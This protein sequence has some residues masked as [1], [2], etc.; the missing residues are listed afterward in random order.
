MLKPFDPRPDFVELEHEIAVFWQN[1]GIIKKYLHKNDSA[2]DHFSFLDGPITANNPMGVHHA[3]GRTLKDAFQR[4]HTMKG[5]KQR[6]QNGFDC[7]GLWVEVEVEK[8]L[9]VKNKKEIEN[10]VPGDSFASLAKFVELCKERVRKFSAVQT[11]QSE[12]LGYWMNWDHSYFT[13]ADHNNYA[14]WNFLKV[15]HERDWIYLGT[16][17][18]PWCPR[19]GT[20]ISQQEILS[21]EYHELTHNSVYLGL[22]LKEREDERLLIWTTTPWTIPANIFVAVHPELEYSLVQFEGKKYWVMSSRIEAVFG[23]GAESERNV[24]G[25]ELVNLHYSAP[26]DEL[27]IYKEAITKHYF[28]EVLAAPELVGEGEGTGLVHIAPAAGGEDYRLATREYKYDDLVIEV[29]DEAGD[30]VEGFGELSGKN[31][32]QHPELILDALGDFLFKTAKYTH[33]YPVCWRCK[34]ELIWRVVD[35]W[36]IAMDRPDPTDDKKRTYREQMMDVAREVEWLP[37]WGLARELDWLRN[38]SDWMISKKRYWGL[39]LPIYPCDCGEVTVIGGYDELKE[40]HKEGW[41]SFEGHS[42]HRPWVDQVKIS[43]PKCGKPVER[44]PDTGNP[45]LDAGIVPFSTFFPVGEFGKDGNLEGSAPGFH[46]DEAY[47]AEWYPATLVTEAFPGQFK[48]WF[49]ALLAMSTALRKTA[50]FKTLLGHGLVRDEHGDEMHKSKGN[51][52]EFN[53]AAEKAGVDSMRWVYASQAPEMNVNFGYSP[54][55]EVKRRVFSLLLNSYNYLATYIKEGDALE[56]PPSEHILDK[57]LQERIYQA[58]AEVDRSLEAYSTHT[59][60]RAIESLLEDISTWHIRRS[61]DRFA[62]DSPERLAACTNLYAALKSVILVMAPLTPYLS[63][64]LYQRMVRPV[65]AD[66]PESVHLC[67]FPP[68]KELDMSVLE[69][70][71][72]CRE[73]VSL[74]QAKRAEAKIK[75]RQPLAKATVTTPTPLSE[76]LVKIMQDELNVKSVDQKTAEGA[77]SVALETTITPE[78]QEEGDLRELVRTIQSLRKNA[79]LKLGDSPKVAYLAEG[80]AAG[81]VQKNLETLKKE[82]NLTELEDSAN[83]AS[84]EHSITANTSVGTVQ[85]SIAS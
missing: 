65:Q 40:L 80:G 25:A 77:S 28:H 41:E 78:L 73:I 63:D 66:A 3:W 71:Q 84:T 48:N 75:L 24:K 11:Q 13:M 52:I 46:P 1:N 14:I 18:V 32:Q 8:E 50:P 85:L 76:A 4:Y 30:Y 83:T 79:G 2:P 53:E 37:G 6:Y 49:Y 58:T 67:E 7:Q 74:G 61:R 69:Q 12:R 10:L 82:T 19:C 33:R 47:F 57:W 36:Y 45:W 22:P 62:S 51:S 64:I 35:E 42:P 15:C 16:D 72:T 20:A 29:V 9:G 5:D 60:V 56:S 21:E 55:S 23:Q 59:A 27:P 81:L 34:T 70:M 68:I 44:I 38:M 54:A 17:S 31:A 43:C 26:F 39:A